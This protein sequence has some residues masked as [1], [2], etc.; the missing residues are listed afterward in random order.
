MIE[1]S[2]LAAGCSLLPIVLAHAG[3]SPV[4]V[5]RISAGI[6]L[7]MFSAQFGL[8]FRRGVRIIRSGQGKPSWLWGAFAISVAASVVV[9][10]GASALG[11]SPSSMYVG[12]IF[13]Q[14]V[15]SGSTFVRFFALLTN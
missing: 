5:W 14:L 6:N 2:L 12:A 10:L 11:F 9:L 8:T 13:L 4:T 1:I 7:I 3:C 15:L